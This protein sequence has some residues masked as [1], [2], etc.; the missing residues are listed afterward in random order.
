MINVGEKILQHGNLCAVA[1]C[2]CWRLIG[3]ALSLLSASILPWLSLLALSGARLGCLWRLLLL[4]GCRL[5]PRRCVCVTAGG[6]A[7]RSLGHVCPPFQERLGDAPGH[8][9]L[10]ERG[11][12]R[13]LHGTV[14]L[15]PLC[16]ATPPPHR[17]GIGHE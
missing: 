12:N 7:C 4:E 3:A 8:I 11:P 17:R 6:R 13:A 10:S 15:I 1:L 14:I 9:A 16:H 2:R 5:L